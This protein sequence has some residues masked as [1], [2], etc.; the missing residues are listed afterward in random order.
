M[1]LRFRSMSKRNTSSAKFRCIPGPDFGR[2]EC[3]GALQNSWRIGA[4]LHGFPP[5]AGFPATEAEI[6]RNLWALGLGMDNHAAGTYSPSPKADLSLRLTGGINASPSRQSKLPTPSPSHSRW[7]GAVI[8]AH[9]AELGARPT[10]TC[11]SP[12]GR[13]GGRRGKRMNCAA[14]RGQAGRGNTW[15]SMMRE[16]ARASREHGKSTRAGATWREQ[17]IVQAGEIYAGRARAGRLSG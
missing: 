5:T 2:H 7:P 14:K 8:R 3:A 1:N 15:A 11:A 12:C 13:L 17:S 10:R 16:Q 6:L 9:P 4:I